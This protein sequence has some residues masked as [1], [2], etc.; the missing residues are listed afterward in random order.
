[1]SVRP[2]VWLTQLNFL[3][4]AEITTAFVGKNGKW[5]PPSVAHV[6]TYFLT[7]CVM[8]FVLWRTAMSCGVVWCRVTCCRWR[9]VC[10]FA[11]VYVRLGK[12]Q[13]Y[14]TIWDGTW[15]QH[16][17]GDSFPIAARHLYLNTQQR[18]RLL[19][20]LVHLP[21]FF[22]AAIKFFC[23]HYTAPVYLFSALHL[24]AAGLSFHINHHWSPNGNKVTK[25]PVKRWNGG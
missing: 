4:T 2:L 23:R 18:P 15:V 7:S 16:G 17:H 20:V 6:L 21:W 11:T 5:A 24:F 14:E 3:F 25:R 10:V 9:E 8:R 1:M 22:V 19:L 13:F 12:M